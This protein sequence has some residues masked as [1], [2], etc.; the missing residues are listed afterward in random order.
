M[1][2]LSLS[3]IALVV[4]VFFAGS[5]LQ[6][7]AK[8]E[9]LKVLFVGNSYTYVENLPQLV[10]I[11]SDST[12]TKLIT[13]KSVVGGA[14]L[15]E[16][17]NGKR[18]LKSQELIKNGH[19]DAVVIQ[20]NSMETI[21]Q[22]DTTRKYAHLLCDLIRKS[23][24]KPYLYMTWAREKVPQYQEQ[25]SKVYTEIA[26][27]NSA[28]LVP[29]GEAW[30]LARKLRPTLEL[31]NPDGSHPSN[32][33]ALLTAIVFVGA[34]TGEVPERI[35]EWYQVKDQDG[36]TVELNGIDNLDAVF[37]RKVAVQTLI[38]HGMLNK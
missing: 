19:F 14:F 11:I 15:T 31:Y 21:L 16:H 22:P 33:G 32:L 12:H 38:E 35:P 13:R 4:L 24:A 6:A 26:Q 3:L 25:I 27:E 28:V 9:N 5:N 18:G 8:K 36:E 30:E 10:S 2:K 1:K 29:V 20:G 34:I 37:F 17:W 7:Q 23:G